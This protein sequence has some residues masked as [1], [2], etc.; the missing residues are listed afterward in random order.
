MF[1]RCGRR[2][3]IRRA[4]DIVAPVADAQL[5][6]ENRARRTEE[7]V[8]PVVGAQMPNLAAGLRV[9]EQARDEA[10]AL[11]G[12]LEV[13]LWNRARA[14]DAHEK[15]VPLF[16]GKFAGR[17]GCCDERLAVGRADRRLL[18]LVESVGGILQVV[19]ARDSQ[20]ELGLN[21]VGALD[22]EHGR[23]ACDLLLL[24]QL[25]N[26]PAP[27]LLHLARQVARLQS[28]RQ[29]LEQAHRRRAGGAR[30]AQVLLEAATPGEYLVARRGVLR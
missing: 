14:R 1:G 16:R 23:L 22:A 3:R 9:R 15:R 13:R 4:P 10:A 7:A 8:L 29:R 21:Q 18:L 2:E 11:V 6:V 27:V 19:F 5:L 17:I 30:L 28:V 20:T 12:A 24:A 25:Q 26:V